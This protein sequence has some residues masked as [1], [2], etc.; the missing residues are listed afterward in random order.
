MSDFHTNIDHNEMDAC[1]GRTDSEILPACVWN[2][3]M[4]R[5]EPREKILVYQSHRPY[6]HVSR[7]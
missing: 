7:Y 5:I 4:K 1:L 3:S 2:F 6:L